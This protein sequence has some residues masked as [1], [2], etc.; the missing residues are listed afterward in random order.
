MTDTSAR[1]SPCARC[2]LP[3]GASSLLIGGRIF[4]PEC[5]PYGQV[6]DAEW[7]DTIAAKDARI[8]DLERQLAELRAREPGIK[9]LEW[10]Q[11][12]SQDE[13]SLWVKVD[14]INRSY[15]IEP[16][17]NV[18]VLTTRVWLSEYGDDAMGLYPT[19]DAAKAAAQADFDRRI[20]SA[21][22]PAP[23][24]S[25]SAGDRGLVKAA[26]EV[27]DWW[28]TKGR[29]AF[30]GA[31]YAMFALRAALEALSQGQAGAEEA[32]QCEEWPSCE[33][34]RGGPDLCA[35]TPPKDGA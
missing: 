23:T 26:K 35:S 2:G 17:S 30:I 24:S 34:G 31:P 25:A 1:I 7:G 29:H 14:E 11:N 9:P 15:T 4:H 32:S 28:L 16:E 18:F 20:R 3:I 33:C 6:S 10:E 19:L 27:E 12:C 21:L 13:N 8:A 5:S 22:L